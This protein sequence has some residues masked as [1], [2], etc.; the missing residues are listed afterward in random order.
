MNIIGE[1]E[2][3]TINGSLKNKKSNYIRYN[4]IRFR[5]LQYPTSRFSQVSGLK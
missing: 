2:N 5:T 4:R 3:S 1:S